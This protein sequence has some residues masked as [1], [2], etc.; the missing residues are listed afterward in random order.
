MK[1]IIAVLILCIV[2]SCSRVEVLQDINSYEN[3]LVSTESKDTTITDIA[4]RGQLL[5]AFFGLDN[6]LP[7]I[8][9]RVI[10]DNA[11]N[12]DGMPVIFSSE[13]DISSIQAGD[14]KIITS[15]GKAYKPECVTL[16]PA[17]DPGELRTALLVGEFGGLIV[18]PAL[19]EISGNLLSLDGTKNFK[20]STI[21]VIPLEDGPSIILAEIIPINKAQLGKKATRLRWGGGNGC[22]LETKQVINVTWTGGITKPGGEPAGEDERGLYKVTV[23]LENGEEKEHIPFALADLN[24]GDNNHKLCLDNENKPVS[25]F[26][27]AGYLTDPR[28][29]LNPDTRVKIIK[30]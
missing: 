11:T 9:S 15:S 13:V 14:F 16:A 20:G 2:S 21:N 27:P 4:E 22:P 1:N 6:T 7:R 25:V 23:V 24:D 19:V 30:Q 28:D 29:D 5:S 17:D 18:Q 12:Q 8:A 3:K 10:C 26:F